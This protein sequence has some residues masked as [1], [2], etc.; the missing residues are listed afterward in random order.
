MF[1]PPLS[2]FFSLTPSCLCALTDHLLPTLAPSPDFPERPRFRQPALATDWEPLFSQRHRLFYY[3]QR[4]HL[5][6]QLSASQTLD[7]RR[8]EIAGGLNPVWPAGIAALACLVST[9]LFFY[10]GGQWATLGRS[11]LHSPLPLASVLCACFPQR[12]CGRTADL[13]AVASFLYAI[14][15]VS[16]A[17]G[18]EY[19]AGSG[20]GGY[21]HN[22]LLDAEGTV[23]TTP[24]GLAIGCALF[25]VPKNLK[26]GEGSDAARSE[27]FAAC[28]LACALLQHTMRFSGG[29]LLVRTH[30]IALPLADAIFESCDAMRGRPVVQASCLAGTIPCLLFLF[31]NTLRPSP[32]TSWLAAV[33]TAPL[34]LLG[35][36][37]EIFKGHDA[38]WRYDWLQWSQ[39]P[40]RHILLSMLL[41]PLMHDL[42]LS[43]HAEATLLSELVV[44]C[45]VLCALLFG[46]GLKPSAQP[47]A[48]SLLVLSA[49]LPAWNFC[50]SQHLVAL[51][52]LLFVVTGV[53]LE[54]G[55]RHPV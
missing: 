42:F 31:A 1:S 49:S 19:S 39:P 23:R 2:L 40:R 30:V 16:L 51:V 55:A 38:A 28:T 27:C 24:L 36:C 35:L 15:T 7:R 37:A 25:F 34:L 47:A 13:F 5:P 8:A 9:R 3:R 26:S 44:L 20:A 29:W 52:P 6:G 48:A 54:G 18:V 17:L 43:W 11:A 53:A 33:Y 21:V 32:S 41:L 50:C 14:A 10:V 22:L 4:S 46:L 45:N 12:V